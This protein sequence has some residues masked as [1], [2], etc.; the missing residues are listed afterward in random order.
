MRQCYATT[1]PELMQV[2]HTAALVLKNNILLTARSPRGAH[3]LHVDAPYVRQACLAMLQSANRPLRQAA[4]TLAAAL[5]SFETLDR[6]PDLVSFFRFTQCV[7]D[8]L[9][10]F[11]VMV[12]P[13]RL[14]LG[15]S[16]ANS[17]AQ[18]CR[19]AFVQ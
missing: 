15:H 18:R 6:W 2:R 12:A 13:S 8:E 14:R 3:S 11:N 9:L 4:G 10:S 5:L 16:S 17:I 7:F 19:R 1:W